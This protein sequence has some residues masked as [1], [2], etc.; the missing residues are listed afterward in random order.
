M[1]AVVIGLAGCSGGTSYTAPAHGAS[2]TI[3]QNITP[4]RAI[5]QVRT[6][7]SIY[8]DNGNERLDYLGDLSSD[9]L[10]SGTRLQAEKP[11][12]LIAT[13]IGSQPGARTVLSDRVFLT[14]ASNANYLLTVNYLSTGYGIDLRKR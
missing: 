11:H 10:L 14:P 9:D 5:K 13:F 6:E 12:L 2:L 4:E 7:L 8:V 1:G 3:E